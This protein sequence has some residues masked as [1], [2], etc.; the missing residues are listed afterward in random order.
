[1]NPRIAHHSLCPGADLEDVV[2][3]DV[4]D[5]GQHVDVVG[6]AAVTHD[7]LGQLRDEPAATRQERC[8]AHRGGGWREKQEDVDDDNH[9]RS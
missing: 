9:K 2:V 3:A 1:M 4:G 7:T 5:D 6:L 8:L